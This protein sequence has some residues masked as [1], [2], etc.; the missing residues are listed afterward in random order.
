MVAIAH[1][2]INAIFHTHNTL[3]LFEQPG[4]P[5]LDAALA[6]ELAFTLGN[7][8]FQTMEV[9]RQR[10][11]QGLPHLVN[12]VGVHRA[13]PFDAQAGQGVFNRLVAVCQ[14]LQFVA[15][16]ELGVIAGRR[17]NVLCAGGR[18]VAIFEDQQHR[19]ITVEQR[20]LHA[21]E[22]PVVPKPAIAHDGQRAPRQHRRD[23]RPAGQAHAVT[24][25]GVAE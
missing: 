14:A 10:F 3:A 12:M 18:C 22:Q 24:E 23:A 13:Q 19:I 4:Q 11:G 20:R 6:L 17:N 25:D 7:D 9:G 2:F 5:G 8:D 1:V 16:I 21:G 15:G